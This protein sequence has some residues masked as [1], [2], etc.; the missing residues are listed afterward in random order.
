MQG[1][2]FSQ[3]YAEEWSCQGCCITGERSVKVEDGGMKL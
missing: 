1:L 3:W 2:R